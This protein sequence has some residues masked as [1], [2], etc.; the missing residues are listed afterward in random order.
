MFAGGEMNFE[1]AWLKGG[2]QGKERGKE[3]KERQKKTQ[4]IIPLQG[5]AENIR[6]WEEDSVDVRQETSIALKK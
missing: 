1:V 2:K 4:K 6:P 3:V 5:K